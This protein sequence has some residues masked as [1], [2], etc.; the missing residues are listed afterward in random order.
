MKN[1]A[2]LVWLILG[3]M[4]L[5]TPLR[6]AEP[7]AETSWY[8]QW[9]KDHL[10]VGAR[11]CYFKLQD[12]RRSGDNGY[13]NWNL[14]QNYIG[15]LWGLDEEQNY[16]PR[17]YVQYAFIPYAGVGLTYDQA[18]A[19]TLDW[20]NEEKTV[21]SSD[22][23]LEIVGPLLYL[24]GRYPNA[25]HFMPFAEL[26]VAHYAA[27]FNQSGERG[28]TGHHMNVDDTDALFVGLG[29]M[30]SLPRHWS[31]ELYYRRMENADVDAKSDLSGEVTRRG[32]FPM[33]YDLFALGASY[34]L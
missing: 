31:C 14:D 1:S 22:G 21:E 15:S 30:A 34:R 28:N 7:A 4:I 3:G 32:S 18:K 2:R 9:M 6:A 13:D 19:K 33:D 20:G 12:N 5:Q 17:L 16:F 10:E 8:D 26:G 29:L 27:D 25:S 11:V 23:S 24:F